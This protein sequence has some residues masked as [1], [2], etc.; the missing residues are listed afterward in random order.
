MPRYLVYAP[1]LGAVT[2]SVVADT[3]EDAKQRLL[4]CSWL[5]GEGSTSAELAIEDGEG[6]E[7]IELDEIAIYDR[8]VNGN[9]PINQIIAEATK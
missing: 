1:I 7:S 3:E 9:G 6:V 5:F 2:A 8:I 4:N